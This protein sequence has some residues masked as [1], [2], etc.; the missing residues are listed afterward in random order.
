MLNIGRV[1]WL[2]RHFCEYKLDSS[3]LTGYTKA[4]R[5]LRVRCVLLSLAEIMWLSLAVW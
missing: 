3:F 2:F 5:L 4:L 1:G